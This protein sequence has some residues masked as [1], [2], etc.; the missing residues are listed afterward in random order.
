MQATNQFMQRHNALQVPNLPFYPCLEVQPCSGQSFIGELL[1]ATSTQ[2][3]DMALEPQSSTHIQSF[4]RSP[5]N[6]EYAKIIVS[7]L[8]PFL[9]TL[10]R[11][12][13]GNYVSQLILEISEDPIFKVASDSVLQ[14][15]QELS[16]DAHGTRVV[17]RLIIVATLRNVSSAVIK[18]LELPAKQ[19]AVDPHGC[20]VILKAIEELPCIWLYKT[21]LDDSKVACSRWGVVV[22]KRMIEK[23]PN[24]DCMDAVLQ[25][26][27]SHFSHMLTDPFGNY[28][29]Q[30][31]LQKPDICKSGIGCIA[32]T[33]MVELVASDF[34]RYANN[35]YSCNTVEL[36]AKIS[37]SMLVDK[38][39]LVRRPI[40]TVISDRYGY[41]VLKTLISVSNPL[42]RRHLFDLF[43]DDLGV[44]ICESHKLD[45]S[46][47][48]LIRKLKQLIPD[49]NHSSG[50]TN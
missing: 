18:A 48:R 30:Y 41:F 20:Y 34:A 15:L 35:K 2:L 21:L 31:I 49:W 25:M 29:I 7:R 6:S 38:L 28:A 19:L 16:T 47:Q 1:S 22:I 50:I 11:D 8:L 40:A 42:Q 43:L 10:C 17:Q 13:V 5:S 26:T 36:I 23:A 33:R 9:L 32:L 14:H 12:P 27:T 3:L 24:V 45:P 39:C 46:R 37:G 44:S 4:M